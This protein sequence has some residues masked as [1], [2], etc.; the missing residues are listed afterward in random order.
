[1]SQ[2]DRREGDS[3][4]EYFIPAGG[5]SRHLIFPGVEI[6]TTAGPNVM[7]S[8]VTAPTK[9]RGSEKNNTRPA[10]NWP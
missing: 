6:R 7:L 3:A 9:G 4:A 1:M 5:G 8:V 10:C 2:G